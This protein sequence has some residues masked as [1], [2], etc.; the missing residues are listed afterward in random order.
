MKT[1]RHSDNFPVGSPPPG[2][3][4][5]DRIVLKEIAPA[6]FETTLSWLQSESLRRELVI[7]QY[8]YSEK[9]TAEWYEDYRNNPSRLIYVAFL[10]ETGIAVGQIGFNRID[11]TLRNG[12]MHMF[13][14]EPENCGKGYAQEMLRLFLGVA[15]KHLNL[16]KVWLKV[17][18]DNIRAI[19]FYEKTGFVREGHL[20]HHEIF[21]GE[22]LSKY[23][24][25][26]L[27]SPRDHHDT[28]AK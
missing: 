10:K 3:V 1:R 6:Y 5:G 4:H 26:Y 13:I 27:S 2:A 21:N 17:N 16:S 18:D 28:D 11:H 19:R 24:Y 23:I 25:R 22:L 12:E 15:F 14:G 7:T 20:K 8:P 9:E